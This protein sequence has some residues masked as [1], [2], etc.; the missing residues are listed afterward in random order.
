[1]DIWIVNQSE[2]EAVAGSNAQSNEE[3]CKLHLKNAGC[4]AVIATLG[5]RGALLCDQTGVIEIPACVV[6]KVVDTTGA[7]DAFT[8]SFAVA[9]AKTRQLKESCSVASRLSAETV[10]TRG[11]QASYS[12]LKD[13]AI[14]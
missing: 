4:L 12:T 6:D 13:L 11:C 8:A 9:Y 7:G 14:L 5:A 3:R 2:L 1:M 10:K